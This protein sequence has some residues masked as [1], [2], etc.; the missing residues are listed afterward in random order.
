MPPIEALFL[1]LPG[2]CPR[3]PRARPSQEGQDIPLGP[4]AGGVAGQRQ[5]ERPMRS[6]RIR[7]G[8]PVAAVRGLESE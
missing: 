7:A 5:E 4:Q 3:A 1:L 8:A 2:S 6:I